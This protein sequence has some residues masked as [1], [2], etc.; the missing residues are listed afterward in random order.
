MAITTTAEYKTHAG[1]TVATDDTYIGTLVTA[2]QEDFE[3]EIGYTLDGAERTEVYSGRGGQEIVLKARPVVSITSVTPLGADSV[4]GTAWAAT[5][6]KIDLEAGI[7]S[8]TPR[9]VGRYTYDEFGVPTGEFEVG[10]AFD[11]QFLNVTVVYKAGWGSAPYTAAPTR[12]K[13]LLWK[14][15]DALYTSDRISTEGG[16]A[17]RP[18]YDALVIESARLWRRHFP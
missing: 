17:D 11:D 5:D 18:D 12:L 15:I 7:L 13:R 6:Y 2:T 9:N 3:G 10:P 14:L 4:A 1:I 8:L 16:A